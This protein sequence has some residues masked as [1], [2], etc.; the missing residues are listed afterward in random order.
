M[1]HVAQCGHWAT[2]VLVGYLCSVAGPLVPHLCP[3]AGV[4][5]PHL[6]P[7]AGMTVPNLSLAARVLVPHIL[8]VPAS[9]CPN[10][11]L[12][13]RV[14]EVLAPHPQGSPPGTLG[15]GTAPVPGRCCCYMIACR[16]GSGATLEPPALVLV[17]NPSS[18]TAL[19]WLMLPAPELRRHHSLPPL[20]SYM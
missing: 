18:S 8:V 16:S 4:T 12:N 6:C 1:R 2:W 5:V 7:G 17:P 15:R 19:A 9:S 14:G 11:G 3:G 20:P 13:S 10:T